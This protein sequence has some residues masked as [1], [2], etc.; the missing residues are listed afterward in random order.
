MLLREEG[1]QI[2]NRLIEG[3]RK[4]IRL[5]IEGKRPLMQAPMRELMDEIL[6]RSCP[7]ASYLEARIASDRG[8]QINRAELFGMF[9]DWLRERNQRPWTRED[10]NKRA[11]EVMKR[12]FSASLSNSV[13]GGGKG[14]R[15]V[16]WLTEQEIA[17]AD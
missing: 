7:V 1:T 16:R 11:A 17:N 4:R 3:G 6:R 2:L 12:A 14:W 15:G 13:D 8:H 10:F 5:R 9:G